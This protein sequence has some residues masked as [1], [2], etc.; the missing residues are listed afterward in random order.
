MEKELNKYI[1][2]IFI[3]NDWNGK[4]WVK[5]QYCNRSDRK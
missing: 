2:W 3:I 4:V 1:L 5:L